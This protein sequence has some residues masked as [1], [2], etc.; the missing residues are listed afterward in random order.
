VWEREREGGSSPLG[1]AAATPTASGWLARV[2]GLRARLLGLYKS[3]SG[4]DLVAGRLAVCQRHEWPPSSQEERTALREETTSLLERIEATRAD[5]AFAAEMCV[6]RGDFESNQVMKVL[7]IVSTALLPLT[8]LTAYYGMN[9]DRSVMPELDSGD[10]LLF[11]RRLSAGWV[12]LV[13]A[14]A[15]VSSLAGSGNPFDWWP[16]RD[17]WPE[18]WWPRNPG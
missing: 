13:L 7:S 4:L 15:T 12:G 10:A 14:H 18:N 16:V 5:A 9:F 1:A 8:I 11:W 6:A 17:W 3:A 2:G